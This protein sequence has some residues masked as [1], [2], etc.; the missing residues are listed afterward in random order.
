MFFVLT[1]L[2]YLPLYRLYVKAIFDCL[3]EFLFCSS[4]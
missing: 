4:Y 1:Q 2:K 3:K